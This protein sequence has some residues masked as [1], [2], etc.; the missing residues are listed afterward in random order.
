MSFNTSH[1][2]VYPPENTVCI[3]G[4]QCFN[5][6]HVVVYLIRLTITL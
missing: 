4:K 5:T 6:S 3:G 1:V 2:V